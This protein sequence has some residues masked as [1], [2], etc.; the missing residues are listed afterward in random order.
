M[1][2]YHVLFCICFFY[3]A[4]WDFIMFYVSVFYSFLLLRRAPCYVY[5]T[6][7]ISFLSFDISVVTLFGVIMSKAALNIFIE[8]F[9]GPCLYFS[10]INIQEWNCWVLEWVLNSLKTCCQFL[11][12][13][14]P[15][16][17]PTSNVGFLFH[18]L[19]NSV[20]RSISS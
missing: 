14:L 7:C 13:V 15:F 19:S 2:S 17:R 20:V 10:Y 3:S 8:P 1:E 11:T 12:V 6:I 5:I 16:Y 18:I 4:L 9:C